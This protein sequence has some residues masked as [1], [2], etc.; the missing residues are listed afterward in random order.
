MNPHDLAARMQRIVVEKLRSDLTAATERLQAIIDWAD[1]ALTHP[2]EFNSHGVHNL[3]GPTFDAAR[4]FLAA[5]TKE[6]DQ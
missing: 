4:E 3:D 1:F 6:Q 5:L 2:D